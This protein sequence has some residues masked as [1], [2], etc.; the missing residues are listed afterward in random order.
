[1][2]L[3]SGA[4]FVFCFLDVFV[5]LSMMDVVQDAWPAAFVGSLIAFALGLCAPTV[6]SFV[7]R[8]DQQ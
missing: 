4:L 1:M 2:K 8:K 6:H 5:V 3:A 7:V